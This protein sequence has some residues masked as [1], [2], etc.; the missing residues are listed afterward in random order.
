LT[1]LDAVAVHVPPDAVAVDDLAEPLGLTPRQAQLFRRFHGLDRI[2]IAP[3]AGP[4][5]QITAAANALDGLRGRENCV[6]YLLYARGTPTAVPYPMSPPEELRRALGLH[7][8]VAFTVTHHACATGLLALDIA[9]RLLDADADPDALALVVAGEKVFTRDVH[10]MPGT[11]ICAEASAACL[12]RA[13]GDR[14]RILSY[15]STLRGEFDG[16]LAEDPELLARFQKE[17]PAVLA[18][19]VEEAVHRAGLS[20]LDRIDLILP[21]NVNR[22]SWQTF[23]RRTGYPADRVL[24]ENVPRIGHSFAADAFI[25]YRTA[26][27]R[28]LL[29]PGAHYLVAAAGIGAVFSAMV[30]RH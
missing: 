14:D 23:C 27:D 11:S 16:R 7:R 18:Q 28:G 30:L 21:H 9:G 10:L 19:V 6:R 26:V 5:E 2:A 1:V 29:A 24:L 22:V 20:G 17:Y 4:V 3:G 13:N 25:N 15:A 8:A 12:V